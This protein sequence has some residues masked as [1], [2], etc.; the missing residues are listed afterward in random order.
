MSNESMPEIEYQKAQDSAEH[1]DNLLW[2]VTSI[3]WAGNLVLLGFVLNNITDPNLRFFLTLLSI[4]GI[5]L[6]TCMC[7]FAF[8]FTSIRNQKYERCKRLEETLKFTQHNA[9]KCPKYV[10]RILST[11]IDVAFILIWVSVI[12]IIW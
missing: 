10:Q 3:I 11:I 4:L 12:C 9:L 8:L 1:H 2:T 6:V 7:V 5:I